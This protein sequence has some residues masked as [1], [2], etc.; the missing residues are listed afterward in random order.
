MKHFRRIETCLLLLLLAVIALCGVRLLRDDSV[1]SAQDD[2]TD[3]QIRLADCPLTEERID[4]FQGVRRT[5]AF[6]LPSDLTPGDS[7]VMYVTHQYC[8]VRVD[9]AVRYRYADG[10]LRFIQTSGR[11]WVCVRLSAADAEKTVEVQLTPVFTYTPSPDIRIRPMDRAISET[12][13]EDLPLML[14]GLL[15]V[16]LGLT[17]FLIALFTVFNKRTRGALFCLAFL[18]IEAGIWKIASLPVTTLLLYSTRVQLLQPKAVYLY[19]MI[20]FLL[21]PILIAQYLNGMRRGEKT[22]PDTLCAVF[23]AVTAVVVLALQFLGKLEL[24]S[25]VPFLMTESAVL[26]LVMLCLILRQREARWLICFPICASADLLVTRL[27]GYSRYAV[28]LMLCILVSDYVSGVIFVR[29]T[30]RQKSELREARATALLNQI[31]PHFIHNTLTSIYYLCDSDAQTAKRL[32][33]DFN[34]YLRA[35][36]TSLSVKTPISF[37]EELEHVRAYLSVEQVRFNDKLFVEYDTPHTS[38]RMPALTLQP[39]VENAVKHNVDSGRPPVHIRIRSF[40][41]DGGSSVVIEDDGAGTDG[42]LQED[43]SHVGLQNVAD[44][45]QMLCGGTL[46]VSPRPE[47][48]TAVTVFIP[49]P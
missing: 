15:C 10:R 41:T 20:G 11:Y 32:V 4:G 2:A 36:F 47:G 18:T 14:L 42:K 9:G 45:L 37:D 48:G 5:Y 24:Q 12:L 22:V 17:L 25:A 44:R 8:T 16:I 43:H 21:M 29:K 19:G 33:R 23:M 1:F 49:D 30:I 26:M 6:S 7:L 46:T 13:R 39:L 28:L 3:T 38:F 34:S 27:T 35:N 40:K 31:R